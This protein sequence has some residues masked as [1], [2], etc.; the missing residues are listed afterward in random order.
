MMMAILK[1]DSLKFNL[2]N[3]IHYVENKGIEFIINLKNM[4]LF[5]QIVI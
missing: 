3:R 5:H 2:S 1:I 4:H